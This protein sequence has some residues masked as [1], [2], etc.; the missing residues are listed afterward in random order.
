MSLDNYVSSREMIVDHKYISLTL[1]VVTAWFFYQHPPMEL[2]D[3]ACEFV[4]ERFPN[5]L[6]YKLLE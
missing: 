4:R 3:L 2:W 6:T 1:A 5:K